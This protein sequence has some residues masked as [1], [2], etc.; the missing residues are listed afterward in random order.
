MAIQYNL[1]VRKIKEMTMKPALQF[2]GEQRVWNRMYQVA[3]CESTELRYLK[4]K[5]EKKKKK[6]TMK[7][8]N[9]SF[10]P[11]SIN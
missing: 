4:K 1:K 9:S 8:R 7:L 11:T 2:A 5:K 10:I 3:L 6:S